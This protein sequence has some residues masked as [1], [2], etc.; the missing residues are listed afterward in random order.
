MKDPS[1][2]QDGEAIVDIPSS[3]DLQELQ[4]EAEIFMARAVAPSG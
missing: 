1:T 3:D 2:S 4:R